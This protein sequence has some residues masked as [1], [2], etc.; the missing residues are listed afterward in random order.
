[1]SLYNVDS[2]IE[3]LPLVIYACITHFLRDAEVRA[4]AVA[5]H[6]R[7][8]TAWSRAIYQSH[9]I[10]H[11]R[12]ARCET[13]LPS[14]TAFGQFCSSI[15]HL[16]SVRFITRRFLSVLQLQGVEDVRLVA[17]ALQKLVEQVSYLEIDYNS[18]G[19]CFRNRFALSDRLR[20][21]E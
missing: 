20:N 5:M 10:N 7:R 8:G 14:L 6:C 4:L 11:P 21:F 18:C 19:L 12:C 3:E 15:C 17:K 16:Y 2:G 9:D 1:M 13:P